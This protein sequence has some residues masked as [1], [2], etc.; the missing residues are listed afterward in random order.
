MLGFILFPVVFGGGLTVTWVCSRNGTRVNQ[1]EEERRIRKAAEMDALDKDL[2]KIKESV[3]VLGSFETPASLRRQFRG[4]LASQEKREQSRSLA[5]EQRPLSEVVDAY[6]RTLS[7]LQVVDAQTREMVAEANYLAGMD[8]KREALAEELRRVRSKRNEPESRRE[9]LEDKIRAL[10][11]ERKEL[12]AGLASPGELLDA[13]ADLDREEAAIIQ[14]RTALTVAV[15]AFRRALEEEPEDALG[16][17]LEHASSLLRRLSQDHCTAVRLDGDQEPE[18]EMNG[19]WHGPESLSRRS[20][21]QMWLAIRLA[22]HEEAGERA[23]PIILDEPFAGWDDARLGCAH[24]IV[25]E[26]VEA[27]RQVIL[28]SADRRLAAWTRNVLPLRLPKKAAGDP[29]RQAA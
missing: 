2:R 5:S 7:D 22:A 26:I 18:V 27:G 28:L 24:E 25:G 13:I 20:Q 12:E 6:E 1:E 21:D 29:E 23:L 10:N 11:A 9:E 16:L 4:F 17:V 15:K 8:A 19:V 14:R 3:Q